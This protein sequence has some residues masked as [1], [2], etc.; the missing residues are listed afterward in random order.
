[1]AVYTIYYY[2]IRVLLNVSSHVCFIT[3]SVCRSVSEILLL[4]SARGRFWF[5]SIHEYCFLSP[6][7]LSR[8]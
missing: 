8:V 3:F 2:P 6:Q 5:S 4:F 1:M 7:Y